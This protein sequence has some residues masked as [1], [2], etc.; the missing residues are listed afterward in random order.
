MERFWSKVEKRGIGQKH[1]NARLTAP[2][3]RA[4]RALYDFGWSK[5]RLAR[6]YKVH[7]SAVH[8]IITGQTWKHVV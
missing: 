1:H 2:K 4:I 6:E 3:V 5:S 8:K 7:W